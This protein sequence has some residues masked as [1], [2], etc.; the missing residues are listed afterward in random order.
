M[1]SPSEEQ[2]MSGKLWQS[3][4]KQGAVRRI[5]SLKPDKDN[6]N[7]KSMWKMML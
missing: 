3:E 2:V 4:D 6:G 1:S 7:C 5:S